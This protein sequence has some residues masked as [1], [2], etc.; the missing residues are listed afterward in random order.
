MTGRLPAKLEAT[1]LMRQVH[2]NG[3]FATIV[4]HGDD[5]SGVLILVVAE[6]GLPQALVERQMGADFSQKWV[7]AATSEDADSKKFRES[8]EKRAR[9]DTDCWIIELDVAD[10]ERFIAET[11]ASS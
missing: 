3:G 4:K 1:A 8:L 9:F 7:V 10:A 2:S 6:R 11:I 5:D